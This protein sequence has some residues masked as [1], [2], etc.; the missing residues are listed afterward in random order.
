MTACSG[1]TVRTGGTRDVTQISAFG[2]AGSGATASTG[3]LPA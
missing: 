3:I 1:G 2:A